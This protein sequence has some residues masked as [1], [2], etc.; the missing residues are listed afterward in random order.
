M[1]SPDVLNMSSLA[2]RTQEDATRKVIFFQEVQE[3]E[4]LHDIDEKKRNDLP[5]IAKKSDKKQV[6]VRASK[7]DLT[8][9]VSKVQ[10][11]PPT[12][13]V[14][15]KRED[16]KAKLKE[17]RQ[18]A[19]IRASEK[20]AEIPKV[21]KDIISAHWFR[22][23][24][25]EVTPD[26]VMNA[27]LEQ[28][29]T[30]RLFAHEKA[31][32]N[33]LVVVQE[34]SVSASGG[35][36]NLTPK[37][38]DKVQE[39]LAKF[40]KPSYDVTNPH[41]N[42]PNRVQLADNA[43]DAIISGIPPS[44][45]I[46]KELFR[47]LADN[48][49]GLRDKAKLILE[50][51]FGID[52]WEKLCDELS[53]MTGGESVIPDPQERVKE[54]KAAIDSVKQR[55]ENGDV[56]IAAAP[57][58][59][60][61]FG[62]E[63]I[64]PMSP[65]QQQVEQSSRRSSLSSVFG[66]STTSLPSLR[67]SVTSKQSFK[68]QKIDDRVVKFKKPA[69]TEKRRI[70]RRSKPILQHQMP[71][72]D[73][74]VVEILPPPKIDWRKAIPTKSLERRQI[75]GLIKMMQKLNLHSYASRFSSRNQ[76]GS[77][78]LSRAE[79][80]LLPPIA[81]KIFAPT[82]LEREESPGR[83]TRDCL[84][85]L[86]SAARLSRERKPVKSLLARTSR[87]QQRPYMMS[88]AT[89][90]VA[91]KRSG[92]P[93][94]RLSLQQ[95]QS[96][97]NYV[98]MKSILSSVSRDSVPTSTNLVEMSL[99]GSSVNLTSMLSVDAEKPLKDKIERKSSTRS[100]ENLITE[101]L[102]Y[103][104]SD[105]VFNSS[106]SQ[107]RNYQTKAHSDLRS[108]H[109][110]EEIFKEPNHT[111]DSNLTDKSQMHQPKENLTSKLN[112]PSSQSMSAEY[113]SSDN[114]SNI[115]FRQA[116]NNNQSSASD[117][118]KIH[119]RQRSSTKQVNTSS[120]ESL[121]LKIPSGEY[122]S[123][124]VRRKTSTTSNQSLSSNFQS[125]DYRISSLSS[126][127]QHSTRSL[128]RMS[129]LRVLHKLNRSSTSTL[130]NSDYSVSFQS[131]QSITSDFSS[132]REDSMTSPRYMTL[133]KEVRISSESSRRQS[134]VQDSGF[135]EGEQ[136]Q[137]SNRDETIHDQEYIPQEKVV[138]TKIVSE[139]KIVHET[140]DTG[141]WRTI[142]RKLKEK[143]TQDA[144]RD[145]SEDK[146]EKNDK[147]EGPQNMQRKLYS[148]S[149]VHATNG[150]RIASHYTILKN[151]RALKIHPSRILR[152]MRKLKPALEQQVAGESRYGIM[153]F[154]WMDGAAHVTNSYT[155]SPTVTPRFQQ[156]EKFSIHSTY[157][158]NNLASKSS[159]R[160]VSRGRRLSTLLNK[161]CSKEREERTTFQKQQK[162]D[163]LETK[164]TTFDN[165]KTTL[166]LKLPSC[167]KLRRSPAE[168]AD[169]KL[170]GVIAPPAT[171]VAS[172]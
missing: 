83:E 85:F 120:S 169:T 45:L 128:Q 137:E 149:I 68:D 143:R 154:H 32:E 152:L 144:T 80:R 56:S 93:K 37:T 75:A 119:L 61:R 13:A 139:K 102:D 54:E 59:A 107:T 99:S 28:G 51:K 148:E 138:K 78:R 167:E 168:D 89:E 67:K 111:S 114:I 70:R 79:S 7:S 41:A 110:P 140:N 134:D 91:P 98:G 33:M 161:A 55:I 9:S 17:Q 15:S 57:R 6:P 106:Q 12:S 160:D 155:S 171:P 43:L 14:P 112:D 92:E 130:K 88:P 73:D 71:E 124:N 101:K 18:S 116:T 170:G 53:E 1:T 125:S 115:S 136:A 146:K 20:V 163:E 49:D 90:V 2:S 58:L 38:M 172:F 121:I 21:L 103:N 66:K 162:L 84:P 36:H 31:I 77:R 96:Y 153:S 69:P 108:N 118:Q 127:N 40:L 76:T 24:L 157:S 122:V 8:S 25:T 151:N 147:V 44:D 100:R 27:L 22:K 5:S 126:L 141:E 16:L 82:P 123:N 60:E 74:G 65:S 158:Q 94:P 166:M 26:S 113:P 105:D 150:E 109:D 135:I 86:P 72:N 131:Q 164:I 19:V 29:D 87:E 47:L 10:R 117:F 34:Y 48:N 132:F 62:F 3:R 39:H 159:E 142:I 133:D 30:S 104:S 35:E 11:E 42:H 129:A 81:A 23:K 145:N 4:E 95:P 64:K 50:V 52:S 97:S 156:G 165:G 63:I 46:Q